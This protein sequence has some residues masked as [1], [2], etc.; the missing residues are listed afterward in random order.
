MIISAFAAITGV[1]MPLGYYFQAWKIIKTKSAEDISIPFLIIFSVGSATWLAYGW[2]LHDPV[3]I[4]SFGLG[5]IGSWA[6]LFLSLR[7]KKRT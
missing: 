6:T 2:Y 5:V 4:S 1:I 7:Y 3:V